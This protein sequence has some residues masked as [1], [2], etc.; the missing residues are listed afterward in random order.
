MDRCRRRRHARRDGVRR[1]RERG[2]W[3]RRFRDRE[4]LLGGPA[5]PAGAG[6]HQRGPGRQGPRHD[7]PG[8][9]AVQPQDRCR[10]GRPRREDRDRR[11]GQ[12]PDHRQGWL[13]LLQRREGD[14]QVLRRRLELRRPPGQQPEERLLLRLHRRLRRGAPRGGRRHRAHPLRAEGH[15]RAHL[16]RQAQPEVLHLARDARLRRLRP[17]AHR[18]LRGPRQLARQ[19]GR[20]RPLPGGQLR[21]GLPDVPADLERLPGRRQGAERRRRPQ[22]LHRQQHRLHRPDRGQ[23]RP[24]RRHP[25]QPDQERPERPRRPVPQHP[26]RHHPDPVVPLLRQGVEHP[27]RRQ[28]ADR[29]LPG[30][31]PRADHQDHLPEHPHPGH[32]LDLP[33][34]R[35]GRR[36]QGGALRRRLRVR[37]GGGQAAGRGGRRHPRRHHAAR[38][39]RRHREPQGVGRRGLQQHQQR[40]GPGPRL[41]RRPHRHLRRLPQQDRRA[42]DARP[43]PRRLADGLPA[44]PELPPAALLHRRLLQRRRVVQREVRQAGRRRQR[45]V[46]HGQGGGE[47]PAGRG[48]AAGR[49][50]RHPALVPERQRGLLRPHLQ[51]RAEPLQRPRLQRDQGR[52]EPPAR[53]GRRPA[54]HRAG[55]PVSARRPIRTRSRPW[56][57]M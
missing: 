38:L 1:G 47:V 49:D 43:V 29:H 30:D 25:G 32:R 24:G 4:F 31:Q 5:E 17:A 39:Q 9:Q 40:A 53:P 35:R 34:P 15:R 48:G 14:R 8:P 45:R 16:H 18:L 52:L 12:L 42:E 26:R 21:Q 23:P 28:A 22:G 37:P 10:R 36:I 6:Q 56:D 13:D 20:Q 54:R 11:L 3:R 57:V 46:G 44:D 7:L 33:G 55:R 19:A 50:G 2:R 51:R 27:R 41:R